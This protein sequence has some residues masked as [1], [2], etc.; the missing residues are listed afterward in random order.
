MRMKHCLKVYL[1]IFLAKDGITF[2]NLLARLK[3]SSEMVHHL[4]ALGDMFAAFYPCFILIQVLSDISVLFAAKCPC[5]RWIT[6]SCVYLLFSPGHV[7]YRE[8]FS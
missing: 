4:Y 8:F 7:A 2:L 3:I 6:T 5:A 1:N